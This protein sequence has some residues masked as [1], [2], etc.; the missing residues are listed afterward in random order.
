MATDEESVLLDETPTTAL[1][2]CA[3]VLTRAGFKDIS[4]NQVALLV[5]GKKRPFGQWTKSQITL[6]LRD[7]DGR[8]RITIIS[9]AS[10][11]SLGLLVANPA[12]DLVDSV[13]EELRKVGAP[14]P[15]AEPKSGG[16]GDSARLAMHPLDPDRYS[17]EERPEGWYVDPKS[18]WTMRH[19]EGEGWSKQ[20]Q[21]TPKRTQDGWWKVRVPD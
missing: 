4:A 11:Q 15:G 13:V 14:A 17:D 2:T 8:T 1:Q 9:Q 12:R 5:T 18:P 6:A 7:E 16:S 3:A 21:K 19:W 20:S 10:P